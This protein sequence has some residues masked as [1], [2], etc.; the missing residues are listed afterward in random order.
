MDVESNAQARS[1]IFHFNVWYSQA[2]SLKLTR[3]L[4]SSSLGLLSILDVAFVWYVSYIRVDGY[5]K[6][7]HGTYWDMY[8]DTHLKL[9]SAK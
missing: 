9:I 3:Q 8:K 7:H 6:Y 4:T 1:E 2:F 5:D